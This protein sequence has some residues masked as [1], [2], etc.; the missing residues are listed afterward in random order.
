[1]QIVDAIA[2]FWADFSHTTLSAGH[3]NDIARAMSLQ[4]KLSTA[5]SDDVQDTRLHFTSVEACADEIVR[6]PGLRRHSLFIG[7]ARGPGGGTQDRG[8]GAG[9]IR[10]VKVVTRPL[11]F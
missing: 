3:W 4:R 11:F 9:E 1:M 5:D 2:K 6:K 8:I 7:R 10:E